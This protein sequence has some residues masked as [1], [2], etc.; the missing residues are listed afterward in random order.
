MT[1]VL[2]R[3]KHPE[4]VRAAVKL[5][6][7]VGEDPKRWRAVCSTLESA[8]SLA[9]DDDQLALHLGTAYA[10]LGKRE[11]LGALLADLERSERASSDVV[12]AQIFART[13][14][15]KRATAAV[16]RA[17]ERGLA[18]A[19]ISKMPELAPLLGK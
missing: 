10:S 5:A 7:K 17:I 12:R 15:E 6:E 3:L 8:R 4:S 14:Q 16:L 19:T 9:P 1:G 2:V 18:R 11:A 13:D